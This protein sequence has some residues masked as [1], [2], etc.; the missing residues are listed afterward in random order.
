MRGCGV[1][2]KFKIYCTERGGRAVTDKIANAKL[3]WAAL[4]I[5]ESHK[6]SKCSLALSQLRF[7]AL[8]HLI[9]PSPATFFSE[10]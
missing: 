9:L 8:A 7:L 4:D 10:S 2:V 3:R 6:A 5:T 1:K